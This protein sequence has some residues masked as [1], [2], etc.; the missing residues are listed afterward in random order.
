MGSTYVAVLAAAVAIL[1]SLAGMTI[2]SFATSCVLGNGLV[3][4]RRRRGLSTAVSEATLATVSAVSVGASATN[5]Q[6]KD[7]SMCPNLSTYQ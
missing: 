4:R 7:L 2:S 3:C 6:M 5:G 1:G